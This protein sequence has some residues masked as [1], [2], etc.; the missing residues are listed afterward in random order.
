MIEYYHK[1]NL[2]FGSAESCIGV[3]TLWSKAEEVA[4]HLFSFRIAGQLYTSF[5]ISPL[6]RNCMLDRAIRYLIIVGPDLSNSGENLLLLM[7]NGIDREHR[8]IGSKDN[9]VIDLNIPRQ[10]IDEFREYVCAID[11]RDTADPAIINSRIAALP[12]KPPLG[13]AQLFPEESI[14][15]MSEQ[16]AERSGFICRGEC[17][18]DMWLDILDNIMRFG[19]R[20]MSQY[21]TWQKE[22]LNMISVIDCD[23]RMTHDWKPYFQFTKDQL[24]DY[25]PKVLSAKR[26]LGVSYTYGMRL[27]DHEGIDQI[28]AMAESLKNSPETRRAISVTWNVRHDHSSANPPCLTLVQGIIQDERLHLTAYF[29]S[30]DMFSAWPMNA[31]ALM[32]LQ[33]SLCQR[34][35]YS[36]GTLTTISCSAH[37]YEKD[38]TSAKVITEK[39]L[40]PRFHKDP[41]GHFLICASDGG[42]LVDYQDSNGRT[43]KKYSGMSAARILEEIEK[44]KAVS[45]IQHALYLGRELQRAE[46]AIRVGQK[47][48]Q[49]EF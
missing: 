42:I 19:T 15:L 20:K 47:Y 44:D 36:A 12:Y 22:M 48:V 38:W 29:R 18:G 2:L 17:I 13:S 11:M 37:I 16:P 31:Y 5:G 4:K 30:N 7:R 8:I 27:M 25:L 23:E 34:T 43:V 41:R 24:D 28:E 45:S 32:A 14:D 10:A 26:F 46:S 49:D 3:V 1:S 6:L 35:G 21:G 9:A 33:K 39:H 40:L